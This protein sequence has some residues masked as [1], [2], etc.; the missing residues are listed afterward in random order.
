MYV[1]KDKNDNIVL[2][3]PLPYRIGPFPESGPS[4]GG[5]TESNR[6]RPA[7]RFGLG[8]IFPQADGYDAAL[9]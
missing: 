1:L 8:L 4:G 2:S 5:A 9:Y 3:I 6:R 7:F